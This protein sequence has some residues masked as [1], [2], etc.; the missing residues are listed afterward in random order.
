MQTTAL[1]AETQFTDFGDYQLAW[2]SFGQGPYLLLYN[3]F[4]GIMDTWDPLFIDTLATHNTVVLFDYPGIGDSSG[5]LPTDIT[6][7]AESGIRLM[8]H[9]QA[10]QFHVAGWSYGGLVAQAAL[11]LYQQ[12]IKKII[13]IGTNPPGDNEVPFDNSFLEHATKPINDLADEYVLFFEPASEKSRAAGDRSHHRIAQRLNRDKIP[14]T[15][16]KLQ[17]YIGGRTMMKEDESDF[18]GRYAM[19]E[20]PVLVISGDHDISFAAENWFPLMRN[21]PSMQHIIFNDTG[22]APQH[23]EPELTAGYI[24]LFLGRP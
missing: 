17:R 1:T 15:M 21:A 2:R 12:R 10:T 22:H 3:R 8:N 23:Q 4:R 18:R 6:L 5:N 14:A 7:V 20:T 9:L 11:F 16:E 24:N 13:L 19:L